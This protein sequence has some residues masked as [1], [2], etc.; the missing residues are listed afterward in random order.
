MQ[1]IAKLNGDN[2]DKYSKEIYSKEALL[3]AAYAFTDKW[4]IHLETDD[5]HYAVQL[6]SKDDLQQITDADSYKKFENE[7]IAQQTRFVVSKNTRQIREMIV[8]RALSS[9]M[10]GEIEDFADDYDESKDVVMKDW[11]DEQ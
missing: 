6:Y 4:Y 11:F 7:L 1:P 8:A 9:T 2:M 5:S 3:K 10:I